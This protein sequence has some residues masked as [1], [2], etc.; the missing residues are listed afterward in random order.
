MRIFTPTKQTLLLWRLRSMVL[1]IVV[2]F[3]TF[4]FRF[5]FK[6]IIYFT[7]VAVG[8]I[9]IF[10]FWYMPRF[11]RGYSVAVSKNAIIVKSGVFIRHERIMPFPRL[12]FVS[13]YSTPLSKMLFTS[14]IAIHAARAMIFTIEL[15]N[16][17]VAEI[18]ESAGK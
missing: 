11:I 3:I 4:W 1:L 18:M 17:D 10:D 12:V 7:A 13:R 16:R 2:L 15:N 9:L 5:V 8:L 6:Y 14:G